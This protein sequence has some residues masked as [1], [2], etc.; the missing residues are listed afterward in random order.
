MLRDPCEP[1][2][3]SL[4][5]LG[6]HARRPSFRSGLTTISGF[7]GIYLVLNVGVICLSNGQGL[8]QII[9]GPNGTGSLCFVVTILISAFRQARPPDA[10]SVR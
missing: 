1:Y 10:C 2:L 9:Q 8:E 5:V 7:Q 3:R 4:G 6:H